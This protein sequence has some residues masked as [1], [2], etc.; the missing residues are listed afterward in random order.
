MKAMAHHQMQP[1]FRQVSEGVWEMVMPNGFVQYWYELQPC[2]IRAEAAEYVPSGYVGTSAVAVGPVAPGG[3][4]GANEEEEEDG[5]GGENG[6]SHDM[7]E[8]IADD[9]E[10]D[11]ESPAQKITFE[12]NEAEANE[13]S[14]GNTAT[15]SPEP[16][17]VLLANCVG[18]ATEINHDDFMYEGGADAQRALADPAGYA[19]E[20]ADGGMYIKFNPEEKWGEVWVHEK[21]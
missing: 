5:E 2:A 13:D 17:Y 7:A 18:R 15:S 21:E 9:A 11:E 3:A 19:Y 20:T 10:A 6:N 12:D 8:E 16:S 1:R 4:I 14:E